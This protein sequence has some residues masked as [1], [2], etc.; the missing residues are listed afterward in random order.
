MLLDS[1][2]VVLHFELFFGDALFILA[3]LES[4]EQRF[5]VLDSDIVLLF[6]KLEKLID[7]S[8]ILDTAILMPKLI[9]EDQASI[10]RFLN[11]LMALLDV[12][13]VLLKRAS[14]TL[15]E[16]FD[17]ALSR[18]LDQADVLDVLQIF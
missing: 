4:F 12:L 3:A 18:L 9:L 5:L 1:L 16:R 7:N 17:L 15:L 13:L 14:V 8:S 11:I 2:V 10:L 6:S